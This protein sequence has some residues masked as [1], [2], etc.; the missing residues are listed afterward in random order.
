MT[1]HVDFV[2]NRWLVGEQ[3]PVARVHLR[4][5]A[6]KVESPD[7]NRWN[8]V[9]DRALAEITNERPEAA[10]DRLAGV[11]GG[12]QLFATPPHEEH[13]CPFNGWQ[14]VRAEPGRL[15]DLSGAGR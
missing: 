7:P 8:A 11:V 12:S 14:V 5:G 1:V 6:L 3:E 9:V 15:H 10:L 13:D 2:V 4:D